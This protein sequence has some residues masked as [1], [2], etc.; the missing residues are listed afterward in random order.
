MKDYETIFIVKPDTGEKQLEGIKSKVEKIIQTASGQVL[1]WNDWRT[2]ALAYNIQKHSKGH[3]IHTTY[4]TQTA[5]VS[6]LETYLK[7]TE[8][9]LKYLSVKLTKGVTPS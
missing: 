5:A 7:H 9:V 8:D 6:E 1:Q 4:Q 3:Y 2:K